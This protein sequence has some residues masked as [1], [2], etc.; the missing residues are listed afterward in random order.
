MYAMGMNARTALWICSL[1]VLAGCTTPQ[2]QT[3]RPQSVYVDTA[4]DTVLADCAR[5]FL[6][7]ESAVARAGVRDVQAQRIKGFPYLRVNRFLASLGTGLSQAEQVPYWA[8]ELLALEREAREREVKNLFGTPDAVPDTL[9]TWTVDP[10]TEALTDCGQQ[11]LDADLRNP[12][13]IVALT[14]QAIVPDSYSMIARTAGIYPVSSLFVSLGVRRLQASIHERFSTNGEPAAR[15][16]RYQP[17]AAG[18]LL[19]VALTPETI[20]KALGRAR[21]RNPLGIPALT[22]AEQT[23]LFEH[24]APVWEVG[25]ASNADIP[26]APYW[27]TDNAIRVNMVTPVVYHK[28][29]YTRLDGAILPQLNYMIWFAERP[30]EGRFDLL[31]GHL[32]GI[33]LRITLGENGKPVMYDAMHHCGCYHMYFPPEHGL[34]PSAAASQV[35]EP[36]LIPTHVPNVNGGRLTVLTEPGSHYITDV[37]ESAWDSEGE[38]DADSV[39]YTLRHYNT[40]R[41]LPLPGGGHR[42][43]FAQD[44]LVTGTTRRERWILWPMGILE[45]GAMRQWGHHATAFVG[46]RHFDDAYLLQTYFSADT[47]D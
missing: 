23:Q 3:P 35:P 31:G 19:S 36:L 7:V 22:P 34:Q 15:I 5:L 18:S 6:D 29:S 13:R 11:L 2:L 40:L 44:G 47:A 42:S 12:D 24:F 20:A 9:A 39:T 38:P 10:L 14:E 25:T 41:S 46:R 27:S 28:L 8:D 43:L 16:V 26:G 1:L 33:T 45:P 37:R 30:L 4:S 32:D 17:P 21:S